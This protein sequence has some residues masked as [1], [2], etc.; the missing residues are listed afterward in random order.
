MGRIRLMTEQTAEFYVWT[1]CTLI[2]VQ[3]FTYSSK[4]STTNFSNLF[5]DLSEPCL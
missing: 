3:D 2:R 1:F 4:G 5:A